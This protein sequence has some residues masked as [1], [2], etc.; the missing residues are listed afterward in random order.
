MTVYIEYVIIDNVIIDY[1][2]L[3]SA[4]LISGERYKKGRLLLVAFLGAIIA[5]VYPLIEH[6]AIISTITKILSGVLLCALATAY[7]SKRSLYVS[8]I[9][10]FLLTF[11]TGG[12]IIGIY[13]LLGI[14][15]QAEACVAVIF[16][17]AYAVISAVTSAVKG[18]YKNKEVRA[19]V[20]KTDLVFD[21]KT[22]TVNGFLDTGNALFDNG[23]P[24]VVCNKRLFFALLGDKLLSTPVKKI[25]VNTVNGQTKNLSFKLD[26]IVIYIG[27]K[28]NINNNVT[29][30]LSSRYIGDGYDIILH[31]SLVKGDQE[32]ENDFE[33]EKI[34]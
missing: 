12:A 10:F 3:K 31:P 19:F 32:N 5:L 15:Y 22:V 11:L 13:N 4:L 20:Y 26:K 34:S 28:V 29:I 17:P 7:R 1:L 8:T 9:M 33:A 21:K 30:A 18:M 6:V 23:S 25:S 2:L 27:Q 24:V 14:D 16:L